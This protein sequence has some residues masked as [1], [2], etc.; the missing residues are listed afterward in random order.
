M[1]KSILVMNTPKNCYE[2]CLNNDHFCGVVGNCTVKFANSRP[3]WCP[4][5]A[6]PERYDNVAC[7]GSPFYHMCVGWNNCVDEIG[8]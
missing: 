6:V 8:G 3:D 7:D 1:N 4:L 2:C 5:K